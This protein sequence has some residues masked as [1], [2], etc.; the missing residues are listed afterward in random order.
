MRTYLDF[1]KPIA[2]LESKIEELSALG[3]GESAVSI[4]EEIVTLREKA[5]AALEET[6]ANLE[7]WQKT[8]V[9]RHPE[10]PHTLD[11]IREMIVDFT[12]LCGDRY[13][14]EDRAIIGGL[15]QFHG[16]TV[17]ILGHEKGADTQGRLRH[18]FGMA[19]PEG[20]RKAVRL[21]QMAD[22][23]GVPVVSFVDTAGAYPGI[24]AEERG[25][26]E[27]IARS[28]DCCLS[29]TVPMIAVIIGEGGSGG[30]VA[31]AS[32]NRVLMLEHAIYSVISPE[33]AASILWHD[34]TKARD[35]ATGMKITA[36]DLLQLGV[37]DGII[38]EPVGG[39]HRDPETAIQRVGE[40]LELALLD[41]DGIEGLDIR[42][43][44]QEK[45]LAIGK[46]LP[47]YR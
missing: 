20:Y 40:A 29:L 17:M 26:A 13:F 45:F 19:K 12:P 6:Y 34:S 31:V 41:F 46:S 22:R 25:Q 30:A 33:G 8:Q 15:G 16:R 28:T 21:M 38:A 3:E 2:E 32:A 23:F 47:A 14:G 43:Q 36:Q 37:I 44:R 11:Y 42:R 27:A 1:E 24:E 7:P 4:N 18:N 9:A 39:A 5:Q 35:A 10:R